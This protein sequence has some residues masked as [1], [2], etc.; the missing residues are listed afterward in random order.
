M[1]TLTPG[2]RRRSA[3]DRKI[4]V[5]ASSGLSLRSIADLVGLAPSRV[6]AIVEGQM[7]LRRKSER[8]KNSVS[9]DPSRN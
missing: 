3:R 8:K 5:L 7:G 2:Q 4:A 6:H 9:L 1:K